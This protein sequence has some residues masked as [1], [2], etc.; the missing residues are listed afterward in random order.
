[1][2]VIY[3]IVALIARDILAILASSVAS[4]SV[5]STSGRVVDKFRSSMHPETI[6]ALI[7]TQDWKRIALKNEGLGLGDTSLQT[8]LEA[9]EEAVDELQSDNA[10]ATSYI[11]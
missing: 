3:P 4:E 8:L 1:M 9:M 5:F 10:N 2:E 7:C 11:V 6:E